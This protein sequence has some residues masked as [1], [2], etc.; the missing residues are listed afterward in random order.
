MKM[1]IPASIVLLGH[2]G[3]VVSV[4]NS[5][6][7]QANVTVSCSLAIHFTIMVSSFTHNK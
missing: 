2:G 5:G 4:L 6:F 7:S 3:L 1:H